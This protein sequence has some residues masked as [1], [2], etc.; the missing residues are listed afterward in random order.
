MPATRNDMVLG[1]PR[2][3]RLDRPQTSSPIR[4]GHARGRRTRCLPV[5]RERTWGPYL[6]AWVA[7]AV[8]AIPQPALPAASAEAACETNGRIT[9]RE[10]EIPCPPENKG[11]GPSTRRVRA[12]ATVSAPDTVVAKVDPEAAMAR[13]SHRIDR[14]RRSG[15]TLPA[16]DDRRD[17]G[18]ESP[19]PSNLPGHRPGDPAVT[20]TI[21]GDTWLPTAW[22]ASFERAVARLGEYLAVLVPDLHMTPDELR[23]EP[24]RSLEEGGSAGIADI[25]RRRPW[26]WTWDRFAHVAD[27]GGTGTGWS[28][29]TG[30]DLLS[31]SSFP[32]AGAYD[33][34]GGRLIGQFGADCERGRVPAGFARPSGVGEVGYSAVDRHGL[35]DSLSEVYPHAPAARTGR[36]SEWCN[37]GYATERPT[38]TDGVRLPEGSSGF[39]IGPSRIHRPSLAAEVCRGARVGTC[40]ELGVALDFDTHRPRDVGQGSLAHRHAYLGGRVE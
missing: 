1:A 22:L 19:A 16:L 4:N 18:N 2:P 12:P 9:H 26:K 17:E 31:G 35:G 37:L 6:K 24:V 13:T 33:S 11:N 28:E 8:L 30:R 29:T 39:H 34:G 20:E 7:A 3:E 5:A 38:P 14:S 27:A 23:I 25:D 10:A 32:F 21:L 15:P 36:L 40:V